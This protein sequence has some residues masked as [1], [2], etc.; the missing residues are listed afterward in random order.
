MGDGMCGFDVEIGSD[1]EVEQLRERV[2]KNG[3]YEWKSGKD[4]YYDQV[5]I[6]VDVKTVGGS[7]TFKDIGYRTNEVVILGDVNNINSD[8]SYSKTLYDDWNPSNNSTSDLYFRD[9]TIVYA[10]LIDTSN[11]T[12]MSNMFYGCS[13][14]TTVPQLNTSNV[15]NMS[16]MFG[17]CWDLISI[18]QLD[19]SNVTNMSYMFS[20]CSAL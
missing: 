3:L 11:V 7:Y 9:K 20:G 19:T 4:K 14:L 1:F 2:T 13:Y 10:P 17:S 6:D 5:V 8:I 12:N 16:T 18:P 15:I